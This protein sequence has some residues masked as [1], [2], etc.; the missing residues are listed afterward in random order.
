MILHLVTDRRRLAPGASEPAAE[1]CLVEQARYA[2][3]AGID[4]IQVRERDLD[5][6]SLARL[7]S[8]LLGV[9]RGSATRLV[10][11][12]RA[13][14]ALAAGADGVHLRGDS[15]DAR[16]VRAVA[17]SGFL[18]GRS[19]HSLSDAR[20][21]GAVDY[22]I[23]GTVWPTDS[24]P[25]DAALLGVD[26]LAAVVRAAAVPVLAIGGVTAD[27]LPEV[28]GAGAAGAAAIGLFIDGAAACGACA[29][30]DLTLRLRER[31]SAAKM[32]A[33]PGIDDGLGPPHS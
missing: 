3:A 2:V 10:V 13:D 24:K 29:L 23:A 33:L 28:A 22:L 4:L 17:P 16:G 31:F 5:A 11:N 8:A 18:I 26:G 1:S 25:G 6:R 32:E 27:R 21:A 20:R 15:F 14:I 9:T 12:D 19:V 30:R 7:V